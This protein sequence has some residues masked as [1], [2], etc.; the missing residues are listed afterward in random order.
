MHDGLYLIYMTDVSFCI[1]FRTYCFEI[2]ILST[3][4]CVFLCSLVL[5]EGHF[6]RARSPMCWLP[7]FV[8][9]DECLRFK[10]EQTHTIKRN[11]GQIYKSPQSSYIIWFFLV[12][13]SRFCCSFKQDYLKLV[14]PLIL[15]FF[16]Q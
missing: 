8:F 2:N 15:F 13:F 6:I 10:D 1:R 3:E 9:H 14:L 5:F 7:L 11:L 16:N 12:S 4:C